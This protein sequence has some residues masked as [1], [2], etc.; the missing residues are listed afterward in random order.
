MRLAP[1]LSPRTTVAY[2]TY[3]PASRNALNPAGALRI[4]GPRL[5][6]SRP[7]VKTI[8]GRRRGTHFYTS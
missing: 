8:L 1:G 3:S 5:A 2:V 4:S 6:I 7:A